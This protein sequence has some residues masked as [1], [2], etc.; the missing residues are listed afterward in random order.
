VRN[1]GTSI[2][3]YLIEM[4]KQSLFISFILCLYSCDNN[5]V[6]PEK[7]VFN[8]FVFSQA[9]LHE[10]YSLKFTQSDTFFIEKRFPEPVMRFY[11]LL[12]DSI[13]MKLNTQLTTLNLT[14]FAKLYR[15]ENLEDGVSYKF[16]L[17][18]DKVVK[19]VGV[20]GKEAPMG[21]YPFAEWLDSIAKTVVM[22]PLNRQID[23]GDL[24]GI[25][26]LPVPPPPKM[27]N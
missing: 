3:L 15:Q 19:T 26:V 14:R 2:V 18:N 10:N 11:A 17:R 12:S 25:N 7:K 5:D 23:F 24:S 8:E 16:H 1:C 6:K 22:F 13:R 9:A 20:Y 27:K 21:L 4:V